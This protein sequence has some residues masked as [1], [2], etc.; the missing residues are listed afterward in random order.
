MTDWAPL[1]EPAPLSPEQPR[2]EER[3]A[4][5]IPPPPPALPPPAR[6]KALIPA[7]PPAPKRRLALIAAW[8]ASVAI[9]ILAVWV[10]Y[11][12]RDAIMHAWPPSE[13]AYAALGLTP[14]R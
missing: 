4:E 9:L 5:P 6:E 3:L 13:R 10:A 11:D 14:K 1:E 12:R 2:L 7:P 8:V